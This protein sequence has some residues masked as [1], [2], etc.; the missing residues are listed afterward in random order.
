MRSTSKTLKPSETRDRILSTAERLFAEYGLDGVS[1]RQLGAESGAAI[2]LI[3]YHFGTKEMLYRAVFERR[4]TPLSERRRAAL[5]AALSPANGRPTLEA[6]LDALAR[7]WIEMHATEHG[8]YYTRLVAREVYDPREAERGIVR[9]LLDP[10]ARD[11]IAAMEQ[12][13]PDHP[14]SDIHWG[15]LFFV[16]TL[17][18]ILTSPQRTDRLFGDLLGDKST[19]AIVQR[20]VSFVSAALTNEKK[21]DTGIF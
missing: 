12:V 17:Q 18:V 4:I 8:H 9:D 7:P 13:L 5:A 14:Q 3:N 1:L 19:E 2:A 6:V 21:K 11:F 16:S 15:Y 10:V 20:L